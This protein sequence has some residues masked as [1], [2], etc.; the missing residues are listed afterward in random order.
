MNSDDG[1]NTGTPI[2][3]IEVSSSQSGFQ[4]A[5]ALQRSQ[6]YVLKLT[7]KVRQRKG[8]LRK[9][10]NVHKGKKDR[11]NLKFQRVT[12]DIRYYIK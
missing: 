3:D 9:S 7:Q 5:N 1:I 2:M 12:V 11:N 10:D 6:G 4:G 8:I